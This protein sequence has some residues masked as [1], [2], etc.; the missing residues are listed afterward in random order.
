MFNWCWHRWKVDKVFD[1][2]T[3]NYNRRILLASGNVCSK[4]KGRKLMWYRYH[5]LTDFMWSSNLKNDPR[6][7]KEAKQE[8]YDWLNNELPRRDNVVNLKVTK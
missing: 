1:F 3:G 8:A 7:S 5:F 6:V 4:C 2:Y